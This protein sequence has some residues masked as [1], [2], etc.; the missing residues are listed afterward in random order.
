LTPC[1]VGGKAMDEMKFPF[2][3]WALWITDFNCGCCCSEEWHYQRA[4]WDLV[5]ELTAKEHFSYCNTQPGEMGSESPCTF[6]AVEKL[7]PV[8]MARTESRIFSPHTNATANA[9]PWGSWRA[10]LGWRG[11]RQGVGIH[12]CRLWCRFRSY[13]YNTYWICVSPNMN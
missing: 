12:K 1:M 9:K 7:D 6:V 8:I 2:W 11:K 5:L 10:R 3:E 13:K 4:F